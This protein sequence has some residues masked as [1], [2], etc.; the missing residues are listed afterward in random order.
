MRQALYGI[1]RSLSI[2]THSALHH[3][4]I[5]QA[6]SLEGAKV[7]L[8][9]PRIG[10]FEFV[11]PIISDPDVRAVAQS[12]T[13]SMLYELV[14]IVYRRLAGR[15]ETPSS[16]EMR[17]L[18]RQAPGDLDALSDSINEDMVRIHRP[19]ISDNARYN[20]TV[21]G[22]AVNIV[23]LDRDTYDFVRTKVLG[24][25]EE[26]FFGEVRSFN[27]ST[28]QGRFW[29]EREERTV[30]FTKNKATRISDSVRQT[31]SWSLDEWVNGREG[32]IFL[33][34]YPLSSKTGLLKHVFMTKVRRA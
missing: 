22:G 14:K 33:R 11:F 6:P 8:E 24:D 27:G 28:I 23:H 10:S 4:V 31:L 29:I 7:L 19:L 34:G 5:K 12:L 32:Y 18:E 17:A 26:E 1:S 3:R 13:A 20:I 25:N 2:L 30:G 9:P 21:N 16:A 15:S